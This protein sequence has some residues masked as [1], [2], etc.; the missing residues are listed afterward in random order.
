MY[1]FWKKNAEKIAYKAA[2]H[3][4]AY[5]KFLQSKGI[6][7]KNLENLLLNKLPVIDKNNYLKKYEIQERLY[8]SIKVTDCY[9][10][11]SSSGSSDEPTIWLRTANYDTNLANY[12][13]NFLNKHFNILKKKSLIIIGFALGTTQAGLMHLKASWEY[14]A[15]KGNC[16]VISPGTDS[17]L[18]AFFINKI[19]KYYE[20]IIYIGYPPII[21]DFV[22]I[23]ISKNFN[24]SKW[25]IKIAYAGENPTPYWRQE[26]AQKIKGKY[27]DITVFYGSTEAGMI[28]FET[29]EL[30]K[31][32]HY[33][34]ENPYISYKIFKS[35]IQP[36]LVEVNLE[37]KFIEIIKEEIVI[38]VDQPMP[39][40]R[41]NI[42]DIGQLF[43]LSTLID[44][45]PK[46][47]QHLFEKPKNKYKNILAVFQRNNNLIIKPELIKQ[48]LYKYGLLKILDHEFHY[49]EKVSPNNRLQIFLIFYYKKLNSPK[50]ISQKDIAK[51]IRLYLTKKE[52]I[53]SDLNI[54]I[55]VEIKKLTE[56]IGYQ[57]GKIRY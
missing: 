6:L 55:F 48:A 17:E 43:S 4:S 32:S 31:I 49:N 14:A 36:T 41:Y 20:Q 18:T 28:G 39:I 11:C 50:K 9:L 26:I 34:V 16:T 5:R 54:D 52:V 29:P 27:K 21:T 13:T 7:Y 25:N 23:S 22:N 1:Q 35:N 10:A 51:K 53:Q 24:I 12:Q 40:I 30:N 57:M 37:N 33:L 46:K 42:H 2:T 38:T 45:L 8:D 15:K 47:Y 44:K 56:K 19:Y 3:C